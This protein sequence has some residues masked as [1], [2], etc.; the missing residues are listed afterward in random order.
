MELR[1][2]ATIFASFEIW[3]VLLAVGASMISTSLLL[4][5]VAIIGLFWIIRWI[6][7]G[8]LSRRTPADWAILGLILTIPVSLWATVSID[9]TITQALRL[10]AGIGF[11]YAIV[12]WT[13]TKRELTFLGLGIALVGILLSIIGLLAVEWTTGKLPF[14]PSSVYQMLPKLNI[15]PIHRNVMSGALVIIIPFLLASIVFYWR[16]INRL[17]QI[18]YSLS[19]LIMLTMVLLTQSRGGVIALTCAILLMISLRWKQGWLLLV[20]LLVVFFIGDRLFGIL[21]LIKTLMTADML[22]GFEGRLEIWSRGLM[23]IRDF[24]FT[25]VGMGNFG[26]VVD[27]LYLAQN[28]KLS[29]LP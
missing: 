23:I 27:T 12:N 18:L 11:F 5:S 8:T 26:I 2:I 22:G 25:G 21:Q 3:F 4:P 24:P 19:T 16:S 17:Q 7:F 9:S 10:L 28:G 1:R 15:D 14:I 29:A 6:A 20:T 13:R